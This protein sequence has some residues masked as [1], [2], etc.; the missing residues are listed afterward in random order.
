MIESGTRSLINSTPPPIVAKVARACEG[1]VARGFHGD[2]DALSLDRASHRK[3]LLSHNSKRELNE[4][5][6]ITSI[7]TYRNERGTTMRVAYIAKRTTLAIRYSML[8]TSSIA[9]WY[10][11]HLDRVHPRLVA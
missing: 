1:A 5:G 10:I 4:L 7:P 3:N 9:R 11:F 2:F 6:K 8:R